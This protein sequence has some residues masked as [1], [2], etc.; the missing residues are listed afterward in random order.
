MKVKKARAQY[1]V[2]P[3]KGSKPR[4]V[5]RLCD[6]VKVQIPTN[7]RKDKVMSPTTPVREPVKLTPILSKEAKLASP[8]DREFNKTP[9]GA[10]VTKYKAFVKDVSKKVLGEENRVKK[11][12]QVS[13]DLEIALQTAN[14]SRTVDSLK[15]ITSSPRQ[16][17]N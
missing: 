5:T 10:V 1:I 7:D 14:G 9:P 6:K 13:K 2:E 8:N 12:T 15:L 4:K 16:E 3:P 11:L 17:L